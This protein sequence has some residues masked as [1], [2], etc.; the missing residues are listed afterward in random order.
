MEIILVVMISA[1]CFTFVIYGIDKY[2]AIKKKYRISEKSLLFLALLGPA[3]GLLGIY[4]WRH[5]TRKW[6]F[7][8][9]A[10]IAL[11]G[12]LLIFI[13]KYYDEILM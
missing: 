11:I 13:L 8:T 10:G 9:V 3:G 2:Y 6:Y 12:Q 4:I 1:N 5:K 7:P